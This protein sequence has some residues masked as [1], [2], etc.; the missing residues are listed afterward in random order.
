MNSQLIKAL[1]VVGIIDIA[2]RA[3]DLFIID[4]PAFYDNI[5]I[6]IEFYKNKKNNQ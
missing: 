2:I 5:R 6:R 3:L 1:L 4:I